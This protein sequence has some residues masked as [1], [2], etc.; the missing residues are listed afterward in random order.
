MINHNQYLWQVDDRPQYCA[1]CGEKFDSTVNPHKCWGCGAPI[2]EPF[3]KRIPECLKP[4]KFSPLDW[5]AGS[6][7][8]TVWVAATGWALTSYALSWG[9]IA[10]LAIFWIFFVVTFRFVVG[11]I[12][13]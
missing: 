8:F 12:L 13:N 3:F 6:M 9:L 7:I 10:G 4:K 2:T 11:G 5:F 1:Y